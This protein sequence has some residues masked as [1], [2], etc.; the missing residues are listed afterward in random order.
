[1]EEERARARRATIT[2]LGN[3]VFLFDWYEMERMSGKDW[4][5]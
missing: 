2:A 5:R 4:W 1:V 3:I